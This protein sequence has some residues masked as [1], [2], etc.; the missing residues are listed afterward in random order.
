VDAETYKTTQ[1]QM[2]MMGEMVIG[3]PLEEFIAQIDHTHSV[4]PCLDPTLYMKA[5]DRLDMIREI[6]VALKGFQDAVVAFIQ[7]FPI[8]MRCDGN[9]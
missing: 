7:K 1:A 9:H 6:A 8:F 3:M 4:A 2:Q 5:G